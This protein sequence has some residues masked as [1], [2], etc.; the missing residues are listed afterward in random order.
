MSEAEAWEAG[1]KAWVERIRSGMGGR[2]HAHDASV[3]ELLPPPAGATL[4][5]GCGEGRLTRELASRGYDVVGFDGSQTLVAEARTADPAGRY[6]VARV[7]ALPVEDASAQLVVC[8]NVLPHVHDLD[9][10]A[11]EFARVVAAGGALLAGTIHPVAQAG[12]YDEEADELRVQHYFDRDPHAVTLGEYE[13]FHQ[14]RTIEDYLTAFLAAGFA[15][16]AL[17]EIPGPSGSVPLYLDLL[18]TRR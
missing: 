18:F 7:D 14:H 5:V 2:V 17:R 13:V 10:A 8:V 12:T 4:D 9:A 16:A 11:R 6:Q 15:L 1:A 3:Y